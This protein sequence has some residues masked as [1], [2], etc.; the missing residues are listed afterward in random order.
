[1][2]R[3]TSGRSK[4][5]TKTLC[6]LIGSRYYPSNEEILMDDETVVRCYDENDILLGDMTLREAMMAGATG[7]KDVVLRNS[8]ISP[9]VIKI[10]SYKRQLLKRL[11]KKLGKEM[12]EKDMKS[13]SI[14]LANTI[15]F[16]DL[17]N[18]KKQAQ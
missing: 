17:E 1:M 9:P 18:K 11:F 12:D 8:T 7:K 10:M 13:K 6:D 5:N 3:S 14:R 2:I 4:I 16:H 15:S